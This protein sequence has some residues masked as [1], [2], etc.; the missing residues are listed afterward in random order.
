MT[1]ER[2]NPGVEQSSTSSEELKEGTN[3]SMDSFA[4]KKG[5]TINGGNTNRPVRLSRAQAKW[6]NTLLLSLIIERSTQD[7]SFKSYNAFMDYVLCGIPP[8]RE[9]IGEAEYQLITGEQPGSKSS[10]Y[11]E[12]RD[13]KRRLPFTDTD[14][15][16]LLKVATE[17]F[18]SV[19]C[20]VAIDKFTFKDRVDLDLLLSEISAD[21]PPGT[22]DAL[23]SQYL[24]EVNG[25]G[26]K[27]LPYLALIKRK[28]GDWDVI[29][30]DPKREELELC[31]D[32]L[33]DKLTNPC[34]IELIWSYWHEESMLVQTMNA[35]SR[36]F[37]NIRGPAD[38][39]PLA[40]FEIDPLRP[41]N[42]LLWG[43]VQDEQ[44]RLTVVRRAY[45]YD[46]HYGL[47]LY[48]K[49]VP[50]L[51]TA[52]SR[53][54]FLEAFH[55]LLYLCSVFFQQDDDTTVIADG[56]PVLNALKDVHMLLVEGQHNQFGDLPA[57]A[58]IEMLMQEWLLARPE[59]REFLPSR[60]M[61][62][63][64]EDWMERVEAM[65]RLQGWT[66]TSVLH[67]R[68]LGVF[69]EQLLLSIRFGDWSEIDDPAA[70]VLWARFWRP[71]IQG[72][73]YAYRVATGVELTAAMTS[74]Q[75]SALRSTPPS[76][77]LRQ[78]LASGAGMALP[79][80]AVNA[81]ANGSGGAK[82]AQVS[83]GRNGR[84]RNNGA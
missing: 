72:Y 65:K 61:V 4:A 62:D 49:A 81:S 46:H 43:Y 34:L 16:R 35:I 82:R 10:T 29:P 76:L 68:N 9:T 15:Y 11:K 83:A 78:R 54:K 39:D 80:G 45:E 19:N 74:G 12:L 41:L 38:R 84:G 69:G 31:Y 8:S 28:L 1:E 24:V 53:S 57:T 77:L 26:D 17:A 32:I 60:T 70:A 5:N 37:Q 2:S 7:L 56:F 48:G 58:R 47:S 30:V 71:K 42:N 27:M 18:V 13:N 73:I 51:N 55:N 21:T 3:I 64:P 14:A 66:D 40:G 25:T 75:D 22:L 59:F 23:W 50:P 6:D 79:S 44:H 63:Y 67:F 36:R 52:D 33:Q 20:A